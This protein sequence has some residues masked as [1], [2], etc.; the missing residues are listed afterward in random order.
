MSLDELLMF[1]KACYN[2]YC[3]VVCVCGTRAYCKSKASPTARST[4]NMLCNC[5]L[6]S[7][8]VN[9]HSVLEAEL[10]ADMCTQ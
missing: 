5:L 3:V 1:V 7:L 4:N 8:D 6:F 2:D 10:H 9:L